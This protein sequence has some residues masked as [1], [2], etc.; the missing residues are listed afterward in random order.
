MTTTLY[1]KGLISIIHRIQ[2]LNSDV[3]ALWIGIYEKSLRLA[4][5]VNQ[6]TIGGANR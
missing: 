2:Y 3:G 5:L 4:F 1:H 6:E